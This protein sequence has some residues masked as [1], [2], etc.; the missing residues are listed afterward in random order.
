MTY[1][2]TF[3]PT[4]YA[5]LGTSLEDIQKLT[6]GEHLVLPAVDGKAMGRARL[7]VYDWLWHTGL[8]GEFKIKVLSATEILITR[9]LRSVLV[10]EEGRGNRG[11]LAEASAPFVETLIDLWGTKEAARAV[12]KWI[13]N[14]RLTKEEGEALWN[15]VDEIMR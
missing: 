2:K 4:R 9:R 15:K 10:E 8:K 13:S 1:S 14:G 11:K 7:L 6:P 5:P 12:D 3:N